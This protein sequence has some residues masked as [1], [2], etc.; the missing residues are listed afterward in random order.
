MGSGDAVTGAGHCPRACAHAR[1]RRRRGGG[2][3]GGVPVTTIA[4]TTDA[5]IGRPRPFSRGGGKTS[6]PPSQDL[7]R[8][9]VDCNF[10]MPSS[11]GDV[12]I[13]CR[14]LLWGVKSNYAGVP[15]DVIVGAN[16]VALPYDPVVLA[17][18]FHA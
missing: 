12:I 11:S 8:S 2:W 5:M 14:L 3:M 10:W 6:C 16:V 15:Y 1:K 9:N 13:S 18:I 4:M 7:M 17:Q